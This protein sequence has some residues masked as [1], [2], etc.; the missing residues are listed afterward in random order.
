[1]EDRLCL[2]TDFLINLLRNKKEEVDFIKKNEDNKTLATTYINLFELYYGAFKYGKI[3]EILAIE[4]IK[5][6]LKILNLDDNVVRRAGELAVKLEKSGK[7][8]GFKDLLIGVIAL[9]NKFSLKT[10]NIKDFSKIDGLNLIK[11]F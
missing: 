5:E 2:D 11:S 6:R 7:M 1:M 3:R 9:S 8:L 10:Y 4:L